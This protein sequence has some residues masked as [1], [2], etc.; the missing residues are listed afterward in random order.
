MSDSATSTSPIPSGM[1]LLTSF[2]EFLM[3]GEFGFGGLVWILVASS[4][5]PNPDLQGWLMF[6]LISCFI[7]TALLF[8]LYFAGVQNYSPS[9]TALDATYHILTAA[10][11]LSVAVMEARDTSSWRSQFYFGTFYNLNVAASVFAFV[12]TL[13]YAIHAAFSISR[14]KSSS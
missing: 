14:W 1:K 8:T 9:W 7:V 13:L 4:E 3:I 2:P 6:V 5:I 11:Y 12:A 10:F